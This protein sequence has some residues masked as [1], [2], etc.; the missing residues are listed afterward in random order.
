MLESIK[1]RRIL[2]RNVQNNFLDS[3]LLK[4]KIEKIILDFK[5]FKFKQ[6]NKLTVLKILGNLKIREGRFMEGRFMNGI[7]NSNYDFEKFSDMIDFYKNVRLIGWLKDIKRSNLSIFWIYRKYQFEIVFFLEKELGTDVEEERKI[8]NMTSTGFLKLF[9]FEYDNFFERYALEM[10]VINYILG[11]ELASSLKLANSLFVIMLNLYLYLIVKLLS[12]LYYN[13]SK[14]FLF[15]NLIFLNYILVDKINRVQEL[16]LSWLRTFFMFYTKKQRILNWDILNGLDNMI[17][18]IY[19]LFYDICYFLIDLVK[20]RDLVKNLFLII[21]RISVNLLNNVKLLLFYFLLLN[22][23]LLIIITLNIF[24]IYYCIFNLFNL[25]NKYL[26]KYNLLFKLVKH[27]Y[28][29]WRN[30]WK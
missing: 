8:F 2:E 28:I 27:Q 12:V 7:L 11:K 29:S 26:Y 17:K 9:F 21:A 19:Q 15:V 1:I 20:S 16:N 6:N 4:G 13:V 25:F 30:Q 10:V 24:V 23:G 22:E 18:F 14:Y 5:M 3:D